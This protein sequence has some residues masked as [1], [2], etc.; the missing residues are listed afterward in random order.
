MVDLAL[1]SPQDKS[2][3]HVRFENQDA[4]SESLLEESRYQLRCPKTRVP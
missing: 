1:D 3:Y 4:L 2:R